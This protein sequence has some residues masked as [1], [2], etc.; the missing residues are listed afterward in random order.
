M[1]QIVINEFSA[2]NTSAAIVDNFGENEDWVELFNTTGSAV[3]LSGWHLSDRSANLLKWTFPTGSTIAANGYLRIWCSGRNTGTGANMH[4]NFKITQTQNIEGIYLSNVGGTLIDGNDIDTPNQNNHSWGRSPNGSANW[5][6]FTNPTPNA[7]NTTT[8]YLGYATTPNITP[9][10]GAYSGSVSVGIVTPDP[11]ITIRYT[12]NGD[13]P[14]AAS[15]LYTAPFN[16]TQTRV[17]RAIA[18][19]SNPSILPSFVESNTY[20]INVAPHTCKII[21]LSGSGVA[22]LFGGT[23]STPNSGFEMFNENFVKIDEGYGQTNK[24]GND[25]WAYNQRGID[26][27]M[28]D[29]YGYDHAVQ[30]QLFQSSPRDKFQ[31]IILK[32]AAND[33]YPFS[34][35][36]AHIRDAFVHTLS[37]RCHLNLDERKSEPCVVYLNGQYWGV[38]EIRE[39]VDDNDYTDYYYNRDGDEID[40]IKTWGGTWAEYGDMNQWNTLYNYIQSNNMAVP[41]NYANVESQLDILSLM[42]YVI[43]NVQTVCSDWLN[44]NTSWWHSNDNVVKWRYALWDMDATFNHYINYTDIPSQQPTSDP[45][46][47]TT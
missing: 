47:V 7:S 10:S 5:R 34:T 23:N 26:F 21:S 41:A 46:D 36:G 11:G 19:S 37:E 3:N 17:I 32:P 4:T 14:T 43:I 22:A 28:R 20:F 8:A 15:T 27:I 6:V 12:N 18:I 25:S 35:G 2:A 44:Y 33:N 13:F 42:D 45:C 29:Q 9:A 16:V 1:A 31:R 38:Y 40:Y 30:E 39:K 24:H